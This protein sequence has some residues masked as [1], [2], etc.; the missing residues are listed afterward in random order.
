M[1]LNTT[2]SDGPSVRCSW[3][4]WGAAKHLPGAHFRPRARGARLFVDPWA[5]K[6]MF[7]ALPRSMS[8]MPWCASLLA[9]A[10]T[11]GALRVSK[12]NVSRSRP[13]GG[14]AIRICV[15]P[16]RTAKLPVP[17]S[18]LGRVRT[19]RTLV[20]RTEH[21]RARSEQRVAV[22]LRC[23]VAVCMPGPRCP[24]PTGILVRWAMPWVGCAQLPS[25][26]CAHSSCGNP[27]AGDTD[28]CTA[29]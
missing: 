4:P 19:A 22:G 14:R 12:V 8:C 11:P 26:R 24:G 21:L 23:A 2:G 25:V 13:R 5:S 9:A 3:R 18:A 6:S 28:W 29:D 17:P 16:W 1:G 10:S 7:Q 27:R 20:R 15:T